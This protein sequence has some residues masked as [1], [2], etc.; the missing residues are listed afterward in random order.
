MKF[1]FF[2]RKPN[3]VVPAAV[4]NLL[5]GATPAPASLTKQAV[6]AHNQAGASG[7]S[8]IAQDANRPSNQRFRSFAERYIVE[9]CR[10][11]KESEIEE[12]GWEAI[13]Q[14]RTLYNKVK[15]VGRSLDNDT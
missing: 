8:P 7:L 10:D 4:N 1:S 6:H 5:K 11:W 13:L 12:R 2:P 14:A 15:E 3:P 9:R